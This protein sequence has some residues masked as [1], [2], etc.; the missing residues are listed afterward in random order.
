MAVYVPTA[1]TSP[2]VLVALGGTSLN[3]GQ[4]MQSLL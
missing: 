1:Y 3:H 2:G 4:D